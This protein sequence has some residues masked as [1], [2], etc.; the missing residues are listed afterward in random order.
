MDRIRQS[1]GPMNEGNDGGKPKFRIR[2]LLLTDKSKQRIDESV[3]ESNS[4]IVRLNQREPRM[5]SFGHSAAECAAR[6]IEKRGT[7]R[8]ESTRIHPFAVFGRHGAR[9]A[10][11][12]KWNYERSRHSGLDGGTLSISG[13]FMDCRKKYC[14]SRCSYRNRSRRCLQNIHQVSARAETDLFLFEIDVN[15]LYPRASKFFQHT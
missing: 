15:R 13:I 11:F 9:P 2:S 12:E 4:G 6:R 1:D 14:G 3:F 8:F 5:I 7:A 10:C